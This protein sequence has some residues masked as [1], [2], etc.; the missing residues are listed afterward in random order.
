MSSDLVSELKEHAEKPQDASDI[1]T[2]EDGKAELEK[3]KNLFEKFT[4]SGKKRNAAF[5]FVSTMFLKLIS[6][7]S[8]MKN[9]TTGQTPR[10]QRQGKGIGQENA[11]RQGSHDRKRGRDQQSRHCG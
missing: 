8:N 11:S 6:Q 3:M 5:V 10:Q 2:L 7:S 9:R 1:K 4:P